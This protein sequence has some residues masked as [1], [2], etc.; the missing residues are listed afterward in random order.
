MSSAA[1]AAPPASPMQRLFLAF[2]RRF[3]ILLA[4]LEAIFRRWCGSWLHELLCEGVAG[5]A[6]QRTL[7]EFGVTDENL[8]QWRATCYVES[9]L[10]DLSHQD[11]YTI[12]KNIR[13]NGWDPAASVNPIANKTFQGLGDA[14]F[15]LSYVEALGVIG[16]RLKFMFGLPGKKHL[17]ASKHGRRKLFRIINKAARKA[18]SSHP[19]ASV[20]IEFRKKFD[21]L[22][23]ATAKIMV[24]GLG[25][26]GVRRAV[27]CLIRD[28][29]RGMAPTSELSLDPGDGMP[30]SIP[31]GWG[32]VVIPVH[33]DIKH[34]L[35]QKIREMGVSEGPF[36][37]FDEEETGHTG[38]DS[39]TGC[40][41]GKKDEGSQAYINW[42]KEQGPAQYVIVS[43][44]IFQFVWA[45]LRKR[46]SYPIDRRGGGYQP[47]GDQVRDLERYFRRV[48]NLV[49][50]ALLVYAEIAMRVLQEWI[51]FD[52]VP[53]RLRC[54][55][56]RFLKGT[57][58]SSDIGISRWEQR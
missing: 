22:M 15:M 11:R 31:V 50:E 17:Y 40:P 4:L 49:D 34:Q 28:R 9:K 7:R 48:D 1:P 51:E 14:L 21:P 26:G 16:Q 54:Y 47:C 45:L 23:M 20:P 36:D 42:R 41:D 33:D 35:E 57:A 3:A 52:T 27:N 19:D 29:Y 46:G 32:A 6:R 44:R 5:E 12:E 58:T 37:A 18:F 2:Q 56:E 25:R 38:N 55:L 8:R 43:N 24:E 13:L 39:A 10:G 30:I 53:I